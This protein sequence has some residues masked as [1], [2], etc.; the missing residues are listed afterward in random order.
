MRIVKNS[1]KYIG[2]FLPPHTENCSVG[3]DSPMW[4]P[5][6]GNVKPVNSTAAILVKGDVIK[7]DLSFI[8]GKEP[9]FSYY[10]WLITETS[11]STHQN[12]NSTYIMAATE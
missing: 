9:G 7:N 2:F 5:Q 11:L 10:V 4:F 12:A 3:I 6:S 8:L 1:L